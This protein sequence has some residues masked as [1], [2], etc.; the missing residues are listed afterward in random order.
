MA[1]HSD[2]PAAVR[3]KRRPQG[4]S[5]RSKRQGLRR[6]RLTGE[7]LRRGCGSSQGLTTGGITPVCFSRIRLLSH[8]GGFGR[9][10]AEVAFVIDHHEL[11]LGPIA[12]QAPKQ[13]DRRAEVK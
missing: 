3:Q 6:P 4:S 1:D 9:T 11:A 2:E 13:V 8:N 10:S 12:S 7:T 5:L